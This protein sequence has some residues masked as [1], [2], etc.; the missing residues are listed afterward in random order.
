LLPHVLQYTLSESS[1]AQNQVLAVFNEA[2]GWEE[3]QASDAV[4]RF[5]AL[6]G[7]PSTLT[8]VGVTDEQTLQSVAHKTLS[9]ILASDKNIPDFDGL[10]Q[11]LDMAR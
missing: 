2:L 8:A 6:L 10:K 5:I 1:T 11:I 7:L 3:A 4:A 9:D